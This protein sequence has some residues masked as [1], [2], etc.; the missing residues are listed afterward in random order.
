MP[1]AGRFL[2]SVPGG[3]LLHRRLTA[4][5]RPRRLIVRIDGLEIEVDTADT[6][7]G[8]FLVQHGAWEPFESELFEGSIG[9]GMVVA[10]IGANLGYYTLRAARAVGERGR[11]IAFEPD[12]R[13][14]ELLRQNV[15][16]N[17]F[18][19]RVTIVAAA[20][21]GEPG[22]VQLFRDTH[23]LGAHSMTR[24]NV[25][26]ADAIDVPGV[27]LDGA[28]GELGLGRVDVLKFDTQGAEGV[29]FSGAS[30][31]LTERPLR[32]FVEFWPWGLRNAGT[33]P[34]AFLLSLSEKHGFTVSLLDPANK[35]V[36]PGPSVDDVMRQCPGD[37]HVDLLL[38][39]R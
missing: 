39:K 37:R 29:I 21:A 3:P 28:L 23:N 31:V 25:L 19:G 17:G 12:P 34:T 4:L 18:S 5:L 35:L 1:G 30:R 24:A 20:V 38:E 16:R 32:A 7:L 8:A 2:R 33:D 22:T 13:N 26:S 9:A 10:D 14:L 6:I 15:E 11:V 27:T 36:I